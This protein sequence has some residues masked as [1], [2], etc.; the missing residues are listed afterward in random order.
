LARSDDHVSKAQKMVNG[1]IVALTLNVGAGQDRSAAH[2]IEPGS[3]T[4]VHGGFE[5]PKGK[6]SKNKRV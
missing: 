2:W 1:G 4:V 6:G 3:I 5:A